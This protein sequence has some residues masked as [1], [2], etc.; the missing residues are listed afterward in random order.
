M[1]RHWRDFRNLI[2]HIRLFLIDEVHILNEEG[3]GSTLEVVVSR[4][5]T[6]G[7]EIHQRAVTTGGASCGIRF[8]ALSATVPNVHDIAE[9]LRD[10]NETPAQVR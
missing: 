3:R 5:K 2:A 10:G 7:L 1:T 9:W 6:V 8:V 4:M